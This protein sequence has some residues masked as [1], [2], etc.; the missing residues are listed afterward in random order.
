M[1]FAKEDE[2]D[3]HVALMRG[4]SR[5]KDALN[6]GDP[7]EGQ[8]YLE[9]SD[10]AYQRALRLLFQSPSSA[11]KPL[12]HTKLTLLESL[13]RQIDAESSPKVPRQFRF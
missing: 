9:L 6:T 3:I 5:A 7:D 12:I 11:G 10:A 2:E 1:L 8:A 4:I 13:L